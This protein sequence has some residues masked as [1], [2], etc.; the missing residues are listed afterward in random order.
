M[1][2]YTKEQYQA[3]YDRLGA[4]IAGFMEL[5]RPRVI[6]VGD[7]N[8]EL[9]VASEKVDAQKYEYI[10]LAL[11][12][13]KTLKLC[14]PGVRDEPKYETSSRDGK[15]PRTAAWPTM[16]KT[17]T[18]TNP[19]GSEQDKLV[20]KYHPSGPKFSATIDLIFDSN[21]DQTTSNYHSS[22]GIPATMDYEA[23]YEGNR[24]S[25]EVPFAEAGWE[26]MNRKHFR[27]MS[28]HAPMYLDS[29]IL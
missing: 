13:D 3:V 16:V 26:Q 28:D 1:Q 18:V 14:M 12:G 2:S 17:G 7:F 5:H 21:A 15:L 29:K 19:D 4:K 20:A 27:W 24:E 25:S 22:M 9:H 10:Q 6:L 8:D 23:Q 11:G